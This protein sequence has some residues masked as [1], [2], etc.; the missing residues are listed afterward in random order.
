M[1][2]TS[3]LHR[4]TQLATTQHWRLA[5]V[6]DQRQLQ[7]VGRGGMFAELCTT[8]RAIELERIHRF[9][10]EWEAAA[11]LQLRHGD[12]RALDAYEAHDRIIPGTIDEHPNWR[13]RLPV[14]LDQMV[15]AIDFAA[16]KGA[17]RER[18]QEE[19]V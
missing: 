8:S 17:T 15:A 9:T 5:L 19:I 1:L 4:L 12:L 7:A 10:N 16:L 6:G 3:D 2:S 18:T 13:R 14:A 11:S